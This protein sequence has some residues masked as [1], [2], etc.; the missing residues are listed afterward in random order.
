MRIKHL[1]SAVVASL[2]LLTAFHSTIGAGYV[3]SIKPGSGT[4]VTT[5][6]PGNFGTASSPAVGIAPNVVVAADVNGDGK[7]DLITANFGTHTL[8]VLTNNGSGGFTFAST[9][10]VGNDPGSVLAVDVNGDQRMDLVSANTYA[11]SLTVLTN[12]GNGGFALAATLAVG[13]YPT[14]VVGVDLN[15][16]NKVDLIVANSVDN[17]VTV[18]T[19]NGSGGFVSNATYSVGFSAGSVIAVDVNGDNKPDLITANF[20]STASNGNNLTVLT[21]NGSGRFVLC[22]TVPVGNG[23][24][25]VIAMDV[26]NDGRMDLISAN[27]DNGGSGSTLTIVT[28]SG[29]GSFGF[30]ATLTVGHGPASVLAADVNGDG[31]L[32]LI[33]ANTG[34]NTLTVL[35]NDGSGGFELAVTLPVGITPYGAAAADL[36]GDGKLDLVSANRGDNTVTV[37][38]NTPAVLTNSGSFAVIAWDTNAAGFALQQNGDLK[39]TNWTTLAVTPT[40]TNGQNKVIVF[41]GPGSGFYRLKHP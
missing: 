36:N 6:F 35:T 26:N 41:P 25:A 28:N 12:D 3:L 9:Q 39:T 19:N 40:V 27:W 17:S 23:P 29:S 4:F 31:T 5:N 15:G 7:L 22:T 2:G 13:N 1:Y 30:Y 24:T 16:D 20:G 14:S 34:D 8:T 10:G 32:D 37:L 18:L 38:T 33:T 21:N 11:K